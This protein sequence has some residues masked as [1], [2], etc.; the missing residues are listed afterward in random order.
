MFQMWNR[1][2]FVH[3]LFTIMKF[4]EF[5]GYVAVAKMDAQTIADT[6]L[7]TF[8]LWGANLAILVGWSRL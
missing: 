1:S 5:L 7:S 4:K 6:L 3:D 8:K 2:E